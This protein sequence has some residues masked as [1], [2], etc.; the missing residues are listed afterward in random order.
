MNKIHSAS[1]LG[2]WICLPF[3]GATC[4]EMQIGPFVVSYCYLYGG[5]WK[6]WWQPSRWRFKY[7]KDNQ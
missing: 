3:R 6:R 4:Y 2:I 1:F 7:F 5:H